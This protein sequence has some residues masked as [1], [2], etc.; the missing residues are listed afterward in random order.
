MNKF[1]TL[2]L[3]SG[4]AITANAQQINGTF[5]ADWTDCIPWDSK[6]NTSVSGQ[7]PQGWH[8]SNI[9]SAI[10]AKTVGD[11]VEGNGGTG[12]AV[13]LFNEDLA[14]QK[15]PGYLT[16]GTPFATAETALTSIRNADGGTF[17]G[18]SFKNHP[19]AISFDYKRDNSHG[20]ENATVVA[21]L[22][23]GQW[24][25]KD[26]PG[27]TAV[28]LN[29][30]KYASATKVDMIDRDRNI[31]GMETVTGGDTIQT[32]GAILVASLNVPI[33]GNTQV[34]MKNEKGEDVVGY[35]WKNM[36][37]PFTYNDTDA[38]VENINVIFSATD[39]FGDRSKIVKGNSLTIDNVKL[40]YYHALS[41][42]VP[43][44][45]DGN[46]VEINFDP[47]VYSYTVNSTY[48]E[49]WTG[50]NYTKEGVGA[51]VDAEYNAK[52]A[53]YVITV[54]G[55]DYDEETNPGAKTVYTIQYQ[56]PAIT[57]SSL[58]VGGHEFIKAG[59][60]TTNFDATGYYDAKD[61]HVAGALDE[62]QQPIEVVATKEY[63]SDSNTLTV[64]VSADNY[65]SNV[66]TVKFHN[67]EKDPVYQIPDS[68]FDSWSEDGSKLT[69]GWNS[70]ESAAGLWSTFASM[71]PLPT[72][73]DGYEGNGVRLTSKNLWL[74]CANGNMTTGHINM[75]N[76]TPTD[77]S[78]F[79]FT[80][81]TDVNGNLPFAGT[82]DAFE[83]YARFTP[84]KL[85]TGTEAETLQ[86]RVQIILHG[87]VAYHDPE[88]PAQA[89]TKIAS[90][91]VLVP[92]T[93]DWTK[94]TGEFQY[95]TSDYDGKKYLLASATTNP[96]PGASQDDQFD[97]DN[98]K[99]IYY[100]E[101]EDIKFDDKEIADFD[102]EN[103]VYTVKANISDAD[104]LTY[105]VK[106]KGAK[107][108]VTKD[109]DKVTVVVTGDDFSVNPE[110]KTVYTF[111]FEDPTGIG[112]ISA[113]DAKNHKVYTV[114]GVRVNGKPVAGLYIV[115][116][117]KMIVK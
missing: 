95:T 102:A 66:Y 19:D 79:N 94:F 82:P 17:G 80:D 47:T 27:N 101:L 11:A 60:S 38:T 86:G 110:S 3:L 108:E 9:N 56:K 107:A 20:D 30:F 26:V 43:Q 45:A 68:N 115:D 90:A 78:N 31:L 28:S 1:Y 49:G 70:F 22:W 74:A 61:V 4:A 48:D 5:D 103:N 117:K 76:T 71:S 6:G 58:S 8:I 85:A 7:E 34:T 29:P 63:D 92:E 83:V 16:L 88:L 84:G 21:Y 53:Q 65:S 15:I 91:Y 96:V 114:S 25:Q 37:V 57:L 18:L 111:K 69:E 75:G 54:K 44:D 35:E 67:E 32:N 59:D 42:L 98:L 105:T 2:L 39:Y 12:K 99:L 41:S 89:D 100:H 72:K 40:V 13:H 113:D 14:G 24:T 64:S 36:T 46:D 104:K 97:L 87:D 52:T 55:E 109:D 93:S 33:E 23:K 62:D 116:G 73:I 51:S 112:S 50:V 81:R 77:A 106:G 10:G